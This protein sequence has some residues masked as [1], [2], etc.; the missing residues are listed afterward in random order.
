MEDCY[1]K[2]DVDEIND[3]FP[4]GSNHYYNLVPWAFFLFKSKIGHLRKYLVL[5]FKRKEALGTSLI[6]TSS[7]LTTT[8]K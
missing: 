3:V 4:N 7:N 8:Y 6:I 2:I 1:K 5:N